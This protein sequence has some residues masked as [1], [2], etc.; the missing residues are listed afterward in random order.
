MI[1]E[2]ATL[3]A[4]GGWLGEKL[5][6]KGF[7]HIYEKLSSIDE[8]NKFYEVVKATSEEM[9]EDYP[10]VLGGSVFH[11]FK[12][13]QIFSELIKFL[14]I[15]SNVNEDTIAQQF[16]IETLPTNYI[17]SFVKKLRANLLNHTDFRSILVSKEIHISC[18]GIA[19]DVSEILRLTTLSRQAITDI[20]EILRVHF[21]NE[22][23]Y[24]SFRQKYFN[25][26]EN[27]LSQVHHIGLG[28]DLNI[29]KGRRKLIHQIFV[30]P[31]FTIS[32]FDKNRP[33]KEILL[34][35]RK[36]KISYQKLLSISRNLVILGNP[37]SGKSFLIK[38]A[39]C[40]IL[41]S[42]ISE[43][44]NKEI[45]KSI[46]FRIELRKYIALKKERHFTLI[47]YLSLLLEQEYS[48]SN[49]TPETLEMII[50]RKKSIFFFDGLDE[51][52]DV[53]DKLSVKNDI[54]NFVDNFH[55]VISIT[56]SRI[57]GYEEA[58]FNPEK[59]VEIIIE[60]F[61]ED[62]IKAYLEKWYEIEEDVIEIR[63]K[64]ISDFMSKR[65]G[66][67]EE[68]LANP[69]LLSLIVIL[70]RNNLKLP[71]S[72]LE[73]YQSCT[74]TLVDKWDTSKELEI[75]LDDDILKR[76]EPILADLAYWQ[77]TEVSKETPLRITYER[78]KNIVGHCMQNK[79]K[80]V[81]EFTMESNA[82]KFMNYIQKRSIYFDNNFTHKTF[83]EYYT[84]YWIYTN[85]EKK[86]KKDQRNII[87]SKYI[88][89]TFWHIVLEL[90]I[91]LI[92]KDQAD[93]EMMD[94]MIEEQLFHPEKSI[95]FL[96]SVLPT[97]RNVSAGVIEKV[98]AAVVD[99][100]LRHN[101]FEGRN[102][103]F[104]KLSDLIQIPRF[105][106]IV[107]RIIEDHADEHPESM[108]IACQL[109]LQLFFF[110]KMSNDAEA[111]LSKFDVE[112]LRMQDRFIFL[113]YRWG[114]NNFNEIDGLDD[115]KEFVKYFGV[116]G[117][118]HFTP[119]IFMGARLVPFF[120]SYF[121][122]LVT[123]GNLNNIDNEVR[124]ILELG[125]QRE[126]I[127]QAAF[128]GSIN[129]VDMEVSRLIPIIDRVL[130]ESILLDTEMFLVGL[131]LYLDDLVDR[132]NAEG[133][134]DT[135]SLISTKL[136]EVILRYRGSN[137]NVLGMLVKEYDLNPNITGRK[138]VSFD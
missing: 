74:S 31:I 92:D 11:F 66:L 70:Y 14:F 81:D 135:D 134:V 54:E 124:N 129:L 114:K 73:I 25:N 97:I 119:M 63:E 38:S 59:F 128:S 23:D 64:E 102:S 17:T 61:D 35:L 34:N 101:A 55:N 37:G 138:K 65:R 12:Q 104:D 41:N 45:F 47:S 75:D 46:P 62:Q 21:K 79:L 108:L 40:S 117:S 29:E 94:E 106:L 132:P 78:A 120:D 3:I 133:A 136:K 100:L 86:H 131:G 107:L 24:K 99:V 56:T 115:L 121:A 8:D 109:V 93:D 2:T 80:L 27:N 53:N 98:V 96:V 42:G 6:D 82:E 77:Y 85:I 112:K 69:L 60:K 110:K 105:T 49:I 72:K 50:S 7:D 76:K 4:F 22:F 5:A 43:F 26:A 57:E 13:E 125:F 90:L 68:L 30:K 126:Q 18:I 39:I 118:L 44:E 20:S 48:I 122:T 137:E 28:V 16:D 116:E 88:D 89:A 9:A 36:D 67:D 113:T 91:N 71:E 111:L 58:P 1:F 52:F 83:L 95:N 32:N 103:L 33:H 123:K 51:I 130:C 10:D 19:N 127:L 87:I 15:D 84:A